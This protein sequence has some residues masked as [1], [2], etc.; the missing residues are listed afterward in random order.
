MEFDASKLFYKVLRKVRIPSLSIE[1][2]FLSHSRVP[3]H[4]WTNKMRKR[5]NKMFVFLFLVPTSV[6]CLHVG[7]RVV[8]TNASLYIIII[9]LYNQLSS[10]L[11][12]Q[13]VAC[14]KIS[15]S[16]SNSKHTSVGVSSFFWKNWWE[17]I[18]S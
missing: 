17:T 2:L 16:K 11:S 3:W 15:I 12:K 5:K 6:Y 8:N 13:F 9:L 4:Q 18:D 7:A 14:I 10:F 1:I